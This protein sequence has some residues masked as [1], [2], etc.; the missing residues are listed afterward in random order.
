MKLDATVTLD[1]LLLGRATVIKNKEY[2]STAEY[3]EPFLD[4]VK[5]FTLEPQVK[6]RLPKQMTIGE[7]TD[8]T[9]NRVLV[10]CPLLPEHNYS[11]HSE[12]IGFVYGLDV[13]KPVVKIYRGYLNH[14]CTNLSVFNPQWLHAQELNPEK[15]INY[16][17]VKEL[18]SL[19]N[20]FKQQ[21]DELKR[22]FVERDKI[23]DSLG[24]WVDFALRN[25]YNNGTQ[26]IKITPSLPIKAYDSLFVDTKSPYFVD[27][28]EEASLFDIQEAMTQIITNESKTDVINSF[29]KT[30]LVKQMLDLV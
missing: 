2:L 18:L 6:A 29:E 20:N 27:E 13:V 5:D 30:I 1:D 23:F 14:A 9:Y 25:S 22:T 17:M 16:D 7:T 21:L 11:N 15:E 4:L 10:E 28:Y 3:L 26:T 24:K 19:G 8:I 12:V